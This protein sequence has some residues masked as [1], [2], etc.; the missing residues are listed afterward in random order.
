MPKGTLDTAEEMVY[1]TN[2]QG[3]AVE[4]ELLL[5]GAM[6]DNPHERIQVQ[7]VVQ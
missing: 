3:R 7:L 5:T 6:D 1:E 2:A 4:H